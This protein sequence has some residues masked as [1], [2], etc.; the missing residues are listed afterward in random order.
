MTTYPV[1]LFGNLER[2]GDLLSKRN[3]SAGKTGC[4]IGAD[5]QV[6]PCGHA[7]EVYGN[8]INES[9][10]DIWP[11]LKKWRDG[12]LLP[13]ECKD[14]EH[15]AKCSGGCRMDCKF[16]GKIN[17][18]DPCAKGKDFEFIPMKP[19]RYAETDL[20]RAL[21]VNDKLHFRKESFGEVL[22]LNSRVKSIVTHDS[23][24]LLR[25]LKGE[26]FMFNQVLEKYQVK[27]DIARMF[28]ARL[29]QQNVILIVE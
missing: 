8:A 22:L 18:L 14:C 28:F 27:D 15:F 4:T 26:S 13:E 17:S 16:Y 21:F 5:G 3:C 12:S 19:K 20:S 23:A 11:R 24:E 7:D 1:C 10:L 29:I 2:Y 25:K 9:L 6:R